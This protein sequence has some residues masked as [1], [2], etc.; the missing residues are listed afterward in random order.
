[1]LFHLTPMY[2]L[3]LLAVH[4]LHG[5]R[6]QLQTNFDIK[7]YYFASIVQYLFKILILMKQVY[8]LYECSDRATHMIPHS[9]FP[10]LALQTGAR[11]ELY[12]NIPRN[13]T[14]T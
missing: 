8:S 14:F 4:E 9:R 13:H 3:S 5:R 7:F 11:S 10:I 2:F 12:V 1:M 6:V